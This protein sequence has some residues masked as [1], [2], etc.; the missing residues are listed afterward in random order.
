MS[1]GSGNGLGPTKRQA[2]AWTNV[3]PVHWRIYAA[4]GGD[5]LTF[6]PISMM[7]VFSQIIQRI[8]FPS[9]FPKPRIIF[10]SNY[11]NNKAETIF[12]LTDG[13]NVS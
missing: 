8:F 9:F 6:M 2:I 11:E 10:Q 13:Q 4:L 3:D 12:F 5:E 1:T 7:I